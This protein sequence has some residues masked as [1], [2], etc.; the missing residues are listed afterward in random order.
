M[1]SLSQ[2]EHGS[3]AGLQT[4]QEGILNSIVDDHHI[5]PF[6]ANHTLQLRRI[7]ASRQ[8]AHARLFCEQR[9]HTTQHQRIEATYRHSHRSA[10]TQART[11][12]LADTWPPTA[13]NPSQSPSSME[14]DALRSSC[15][16]RS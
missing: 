13:N 8:Q 1:L 14:S 6:R 15:S 2:H 3:R 7:Q 4:D 10:L 9:S 16:P 12:V 11:S 5:G